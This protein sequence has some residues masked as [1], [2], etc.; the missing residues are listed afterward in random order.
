MWKDC[1]FGM[2]NACFASKL[3]RRSYLLEKKIQKNLILVFGIC[4]HAT[5]YFNLSCQITLLPQVLAHCPKTKCSIFLNFESLLLRFSIYPK[6]HYWIQTLCITEK[7][8]DNAISLIM[9]KNNALFKIKIMQYSI[10]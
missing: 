1:N 4:N 3:R 5:L 2:E 10:L 7:N 9:Q 6:F 8:N